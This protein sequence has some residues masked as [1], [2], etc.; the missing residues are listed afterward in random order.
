MRREIGL[1]S[2]I[3]QWAKIALPILALG[4]F[5]SVFLITQDDVFEGTGIVF[6]E[7]DLSALG[8]GIQIKSPRFTGVTE[9]GDKFLLTAHTANPDATKPSRVDLKEIAATLD[10]TSGESVDLTAGQGALL[11]SDQLLNLMN[12]ITIVT[13]EGFR[14]KMSIAQADL[15]KGEVTSDA[16]VEITGPMGQITAGGLKF[17][18]VFAET[19]NSV[20]THLLRFKKQVRVIFHP[21]PVTQNE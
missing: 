10:L 16:P 1:Y 13:S 14:G 2:R 11:M 6:S 19:G 5:S 3:V 12:G 9:T 17:E 20:Q 4:L 18:T 21:E 7:A 15:R 8:D